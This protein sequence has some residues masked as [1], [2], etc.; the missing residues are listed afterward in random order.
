MNKKLELLEEL[1]ANLE[2][3]YARL[4]SND[5][6]ENERFEWSIHNINS[7]SKRLLK[8]MEEGNE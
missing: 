6:R 1:K 2:D 4:N 8:L 3:A 7:I 5:A